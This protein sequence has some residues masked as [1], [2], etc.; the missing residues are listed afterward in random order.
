MKNRANRWARPTVVLAALLVSAALAV[1]SQDKK[2][3]AKADA[4][5]SY[6]RQIRPI[7]QARCFGCHQPAK[8][9]GDYVM[10]SADRMRKG[11]DSEKASIVPGQPARSN[12]VT[13]ITPDAKDEAEMPRKGK[14]L[15]AAEIDLIRRWIAEGA[16][17]DTAES[18]RAKFDMEHPPVYTRPPV[19]SS[20][21]FSRDGKLLAVAGFHEVL[22]FKA[23]GSERVARLVGLSERIQSLKFS[24]DG[25]KL[26]VA[27]GLPARSGEVQIWD[28][29][30][31]KLDLSV[32]VTYD[33]V[34]G[35]NWSPDGSKISFACSDNTVRAIDSKTGKQVLYSL[36]LTDWGLDTV[37]SKDGSHLVS[38]DRAGTVKLMEVATQRFVDN[39][40]SITPGALKGGI[41]AVARHPE[42]DEVVL[43]GSD[44]RPKVYRMHRIV[45]RR[46]GDDSNLIRLLPSMTGRI[47]NVA[48][49]RDGKRI[50]AA[51]GL[52]GRGEVAFYTYEF[53]TSL[54][55][56][57]KRIMGKVASSRNPKERK[58][59]SDYHAKDV[60][61]LWKAKVDKGIVYAVA[62][63]PDGKQVA[64]AGADGVVRFLDAA[65]GKV[66]KEFSP[67]PVQAAAKQRAGAARPVSRVEH[68][69]KKESLPPGAKVVTL[70]AVPKS[71]KLSGPF[72]YAQIVVTARLAT[73][74][75]VDATRI[76]VAKL[77]AGVASI[78]RSGLVEPRKEGRG[79]LSLSLAGKTVTVPV[80]V[81]GLGEKPEVDF[82]RDVN[83]ILSR[84]GC[85]AGTCHG[86]AKGR[87]GFKLSLRGYDAVAD[88]RSL[89]DDL[90]SRR[91]NVAS[92]DDS[93]MLLKTTSAVP[94]VGAQVVKPGGLYYRIIR[95]WISQGARLDLST[96][97][98]ESI[99]IFP[100]NPVI[101]RIGSRQQVRVLA[102]YADGKVRDVTREAVIKSGTTDVA[103]GGEE[104]LLTAIRRGEAAVLARYEGSYAATP[105]TVM[106]D[107]KGFTWVEPP[108]WNRIDEL[109]AAK[110]KRMKIRPSELSADE[111]FLRRVHLD[112]TGLPPT[113]EELRA[114]M[115]DRT[116]QQLKRQ[117]VVKRLVGSEGY[118]EYWTNKWADLLQVNRKFLGPEGSVA[119]RK[120][121][122]E[123]VAKNTPYDQFVRSIITASGSNLKN[124]PASYYKILRDPEAIA[125]NTTHL[126]LAT[127]F[128]CNKCHDHPFERWN[129]NQYY[130]T[131]AFFARV[132]LK[133]DPAAK[134][135]KLRGTAVEAAKPYYEIV[136]DRPDGEVNHLRTG[137]VAK[138]T[139]PYEVKY[140]ASE[141]ATRRQQIAAWI[142]S[143]DNALFVK[144]FVN[145]LWGYL[146]GVGIIEPIDDIRAGNPAANPE[147][148]DYLS[149]EFLK[150][151]FDVRH[152]VRLICMSRTY[153]LSVK[154][155][156]WNRD[157][158][159]N[160]S[161]A[162]ARRL[163]AE[164]LF[165]A[166]HTVTGSTSAIPG[167]P[168]GT[169]AAALPDAGVDLPGGFLATFGRPARESACECERSSGLQLGAI[170]ALI[171][172]ET[173]NRA[174]N[175]P[176]NALPGLVKKV[177][178]DAK[179]VDELFLRVLNRPA[180]PAEI[181]AFRKELKTVAAD[182]G[183]MAA[184]L[185]EGEEKWKVRKPKL[186]KQREEAI[187][188]VKADLA[189]YGK[190]IAPQI[191]GKERQR[192]ELIAKRQKELKDYEVQLPKKLAAYEKKTKPNAVD[193][194]PLFPTALKASGGAKLTLLPD[195]SVIVS[196]NNNRSVASFTARTDLRNITAIRLEVLADKSLPKGGPGRADDGNFVLSELQ[197]QAAPVKNPKQKKPVALQNAKADFEQKNFNVKFAIDGRPDNN[198]GWGVSP[199][200]G[201]THW[202]TF[203]T[204]QPVGHDGGTLLTFFIH[205]QFGGRKYQLGRFRI[206]V[207]TAKKP[208]GLSLADEYRAV[209]STPAKDRTKEQQ[210]AIL[211]Y[212][213]A[214]DPEMIKRQKALADARKPVPED[215]GVKERK[216]TLGLVSR[217]VP[218]DPALARLRQDL[219]QSSKQIQNA[220][221]TTA[222]DL[223]WALVNSPAFLFNR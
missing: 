210:A 148:L 218:L 156:E 36:A 162:L 72:D 140:E 179:L 17:I 151:N 57:I 8:A 19:I 48:V 158:K 155:N 39:V 154:T 25:K 50:A 150:S 35:V 9:K 74:E 214:M 215:P 171:S 174:I 187:A 2:E 70:E 168:A 217:K 65:S 128:N 147:L 37:F 167:V 40:T 89:T 97:R 107:R 98:V 163:P 103:D 61:Q 138:P 175:D 56:N 12:L 114:F 7:L 73:G 30:K 21:D 188:A 200:F 144:S 115:A 28:V 90:A 91:V 176:K 134:G 63:R 43:G 82:I 139:F 165:D 75:A 132:G 133:A 202:A 68:D 33:T 146:F 22:L 59:L 113:V 141:K 191:A 112:L 78:S 119:F 177:Q 42:R 189:A 193:W 196:G 51:S 195:R 205:E 153:Q 83:P 23:D 190:K 94:H 212:I 211:K 106:G 76:V 117:A 220:R 15:A 104:G 213:K 44:G 203:E 208:V 161:H 121:I 96:S 219:E 32:P 169:R 58:A 185:K 223:V 34:Y 93:L 143:R 24:P 122:R 116:E 31:K 26:A 55:D 204:K 16:E 47:W 3:E 142:T 71:V 60:K 192:K 109:V 131:A 182:H 5:I 123:H 87:N 120:W 38:V 152:V 64:A 62:F 126:F 194:T 172:S 222:Q 197:V 77:A 95:E 46:I 136:Y 159:T 166:L 86:A 49:S 10:T 4:K 170:M 108:K 130:E 88:A 164:V 129:Q 221:L 66:V 54:P 180:K 181:E 11:G 125:E 206:S 13:M 157:D 207:T 81:T 85:N 173:I 18:A 14:A 124:P 101:E 92:P 216:E 102:T 20:L 184:N 100:K 84:V 149:S 45:V 198:K 111:E 186:E 1:G 29:E 209:L 145:R 127:R 69:V 79:E 27:G 201:V 183:E 6:E 137:V 67:A 80:V 110:W 99:D 53:D 41:T 118:I 135:K 160:F 199:S 52:D 105:L 178:D